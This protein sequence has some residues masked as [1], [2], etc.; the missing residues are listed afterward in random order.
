M[1][2]C[3][4][5]GAQLND[6]A[7]FCKKCGTACWETDENEE[8]PAADNTVKTVNEPP[9]TEEKPEKKFFRILSEAD[10]DPIV[11]RVRRCSNETE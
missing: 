11:Q 7:R 1:K 8:K 2:F 10:L 3:I 9:T 5:C 4:K 6:D